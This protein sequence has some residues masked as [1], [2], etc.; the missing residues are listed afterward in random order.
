MSRSLRVLSSILISRKTF[1]TFGPQANVLKFFRTLSPKVTCPSS[2]TP[3]RFQVLSEPQRHFVHNSFKSFP[4]P[5]CFIN[6]GTSF[7]TSLSLQRSFL[8][9]PRFHL[10]GAFGDRLTE[11]APTN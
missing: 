1:M 6:L 7:P 10:F 5:T 2:F 9:V 8:E 11:W 4:L 3:L